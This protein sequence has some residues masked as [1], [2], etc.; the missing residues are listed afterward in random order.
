MSFNYSFKLTQS[1][2]TSKINLVPASLK[3]P[4]RLLIILNRFVIG[5]PAM[6]TLPLAWHLKSDFEILVIYGEK[7]KDEMEATFLLKQYQ[8]LAM[9]KI[10]WLKRSINPVVDVA[11]FFKIL[12]TI[13]RFK[14]DIVHTHGAKSGLFGRVAAYFCRVPVIVHTFHG[15]LFHS[16]FSSKISSLIKTLERTL[17]KITAGF[18]ILS[19][20]QLIDLVNV[21]KILPLEKCRIIPLGMEVPQVGDGDEK[22]NQFRERYGLKKDDIAIGIVGRIVPIKNHQFFV[23]AV[24]KLLLQ[25]AGQLPAFFII[26]DGALKVQVEYQLQA[27]SIPFSNDVITADTR[28]V[29]TSWLSDLYEVMH[30]LDIIAL[31]SLNEGTPLSL[32]EAQAFCK[33]VV[34]TNVG[35]VKD[36]MIDSETGFYV[37]KN[38]INMFCTQI[39]LLINNS[40]LRSKMGIAG[41]HFVEQK[42]SK[43]REV[44][45]TRDFYISLLAKKQMAYP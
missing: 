32:I 37:D 30:G 28:V 6:D 1:L 31:T 36:T 39:Q 42:F 11:A 27:L 44:E 26:G 29:F 12:W 5:G 15:H 14:P 16:Y 18:I 21:F 23:Q 25:K 17:S 9:Q 19:P 20:S 7:E 8:G 10:K 22:R 33:P 3:S 2:F 4:P 13:A 43:N 24:Q 34:A 35:G 45:L 40:E 41:R 38:D